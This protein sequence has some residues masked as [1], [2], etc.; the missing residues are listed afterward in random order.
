MQYDPKLKKAMEQIKVILDEHDIG[1]SIVLHSPGF[2]EIFMKVNPG[3][4][5]A[6]IAEW[7]GKQGIR[8]RTRL[9]EDFN[10]DVAKRNK[11]QE[12]T[13]NMFHIMAESVGHQALNFMEWLFPEKTGITLHI[14]DEFHRTSSHTLDDIDTIEFTEAQNN[15]LNQLIFGDPKQCGDVTEAIQW[16]IDACQHIE[17]KYGVDAC[18]VGF[19]GL[20]SEWLSAD[21]P[22][23]MDQTYVMGE[24]REGATYIVQFFKGDTLRMCYNED[25]EHEDHDNDEPTCRSMKEGYYEILEQFGSP[26]DYYRKEREIVKW[27]EIPKSS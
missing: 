22:P 27:M 18:H 21:N 4:S 16:C 23:I 13:V 14:D 5:C 10:G 20:P 11:S 12:D 8:V 7:K 9:A 26:H 15:F 24:D 2:A 17:D 1:A 6:F 19:H 25:C 3:Y